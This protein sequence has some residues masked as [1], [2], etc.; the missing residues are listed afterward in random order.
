M[1]KPLIFGLAFLFL[2]LMATGPA[3]AA[4][5]EIAE[6]TIADATGDWGFPSPY[7]HYSRG[8][9][10]V[11]M[12]FVFDTLVWKDDE[13]YLPA[14]AEDWEYLED[15][16]AYSFDLR[17]GVTWHDGEK[18]TADDVVFTVDYIQ[19]HPYQWVDSGIIDRA[20]AAGDYSVKLYLSEP[21]APFMD[22]VACTLPILPEHV[23]DGVS[24][25]ANFR[26]DEALI[27]SGPFKLSDYNRAQGTYLYEAYEDY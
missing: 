7:A 2:A 6:Y 21:Y 5:Y 8:P 14:L 9:G 1:L 26:D 27:G 18:F 17:E 10:Y 25:P 22:L 24:D 19:D 11:R 23:W 20:E 16:N 13:G 12:S 3:Y 4:D 15:E